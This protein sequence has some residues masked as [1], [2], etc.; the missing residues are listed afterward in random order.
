MLLSQQ[1]LS[2]PFNSDIEN[3]KKDGGGMEKR[4]SKRM[5]KNLNGAL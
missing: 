5:G 1:P 4:E 3:R 2:S